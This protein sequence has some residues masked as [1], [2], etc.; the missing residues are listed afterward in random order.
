MTIQENLEKLQYC[1]HFGTI[2][3]ASTSPRKNKVAL[4]YFKV[5][6]KKS[7]YLFIFFSK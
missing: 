3:E 1:I 4:S 6:K 2:S 5:A 7:F